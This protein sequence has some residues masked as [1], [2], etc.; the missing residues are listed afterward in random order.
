MS[1]DV[2]KMYTIYEDPSDFPGAFVVREFAIVPGDPEPVPTGWHVAGWSLDFARAAVAKYTA[3]DHCIPRD[4]G[5]EPHIV[6]T[7][8]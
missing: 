3:A 4:P 2:L 1:G 7:W 5:D 6:E 8:V